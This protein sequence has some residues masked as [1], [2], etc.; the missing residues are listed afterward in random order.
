MIGGDFNAKTG[1]SH[2]LYPQNIGSFGKGQTN[3]NGEFLGDLAYKNNLILT[4][5]IFKHKLSHIT[6][7]E[8]P[9][10]N[11]INETN[12]NLRRN[13]Y[14]NQIDYILIN[15]DYKTL[16]RNS[17]S[18]SGLFIPTDHRIVITELNIKIKSIF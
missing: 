18:Y 12:T 6:I 1:T 15:Q 3:L 5:T 14:R 10:L 2:N 9:K 7:R 13:P 11:I 8:S 4:N 16:L 17:R